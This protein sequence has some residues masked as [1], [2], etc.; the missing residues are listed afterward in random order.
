[1]PTP[2]TGHNSAVNATELRSIVE[3]IERLNDEI[4]ERN[5]DKS[6][7]FKAAKHSGFDT[8]II[9]QVVAIRAKDEADVAEQAELL[10]VYLRALGT[11]DAIARARAG[12][13]A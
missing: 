12:E 3:R 6:E 9:R 4:A 5:T 2:S 11:P 10:G 1:M 13:A 7:I 8:K